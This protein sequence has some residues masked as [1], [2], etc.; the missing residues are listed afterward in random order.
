MEFQTTDHF[1][2]IRII[3]AGNGIPEGIKEKIFTPFFTTKSQQKAVGLG[4]S[5]SRSILMDHKG[6]LFL[7]PYAQHTAFVVKLPISFRA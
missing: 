2:F 5:V 7:D 3:D 1:V 4:L 6:D